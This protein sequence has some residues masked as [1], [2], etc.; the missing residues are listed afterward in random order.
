M[1]AYYN[2]LTNQSIQFVEFFFFF[3]LETH[4]SFNILF[5]FRK[6]SYETFVLTPFL[7]FFQE[8]AKLAYFDYGDVIC[9]EGEMPQGIYLIISGMAIVRDY[10][11]FTKNVL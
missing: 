10:S 7:F 3:L 2:S 9:K 6:V 11:L 4:F 1:S 8:R 5:L